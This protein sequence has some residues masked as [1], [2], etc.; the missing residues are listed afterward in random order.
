VL[1]E[2]INCSIHS[3]PQP[4]K[5]GPHNNNC[6]STQ[7][8][9]A[10]LPHCIM[11]YINSIH[12]FSFIL[13]PWNNPEVAAIL[14]FLGGITLASQFSLTANALFAAL[15]CL[16]SIYCHAVRIIFH[17]SPSVYIINYS[18]FTCPSEWQCN[19]DRFRSIARD[20]FGLPLTSVD[21]CMKILKQSGL[22]EKTCFPPAIFEFPQHISMA[23]ARKESEAVMFQCIDKLIA[24][25]LDVHSVDHL[26]V[27]CS[28]FNPTPSLTS[29]IVQHY[30]LKPTIN[31][32]NLAG[33]GCSASLISLNLAKEL[34][35]LYPNSRCVVISFENITQNI[36]LGAEK[37][38]LISNALFRCGGSAILL[39]NKLND[40]YCTSRAHIFK[41]QRVVRTHLG[42]SEEAYNSVYQEQD[43]AGKLGVKLDKDLVKVAAKAL[44]INISSVAMYIL[45]WTEIIKYCCSFMQAKLGKQQLEAQETPK[46]LGDQS[47]GEGSMN[48][49]N[50]LPSQQRYVPN[51]S[52]SISHYCI[53]AGGRSLLDAIE[54]SLNLSAEAMK[55]SRQVLFDR[56]NVSSSSVWYQLQWIEQ[57]K[58]IK[59]NELIWA[60]SFGAG[61]KCN[62]AILKVSKRIQ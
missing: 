13:D 45:T 27:N 6:Y 17:I 54:K 7:T 37:S 2:A 30:K 48:K 8:R 25:G 35:S 49:K 50:L 60:L 57:N 10:I 58:T 61:F 55:P 4:I 12:L 14:L 38:M 24:D 29:M 26:I 62:S 32:Y 56:G 31:T 28:L 11:D 1:D 5:Y 36:Y 9:A 20:N 51:F 59:N 43:S 3:I 15:D 21:F 42:S 34:L 22:G 52:A 47:Q 39:S 44:T 53:H 23:D 18:T 41:L 40:I 46:S 16:N 19:S 33:M